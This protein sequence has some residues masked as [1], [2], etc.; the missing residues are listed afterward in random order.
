MIPL[1]S[2]TMKLNATSEMIP[3]H[4]AGVRRTSIRSRRPSSAPATTLLRH[5]LRARGCAR[6]PAMPASACSPTPARRANTRACWRSAPGTRRAAKAQ[7]DGLP[8]SGVGARHQPGERADGR[9]AGGRD[10]VRREGNVDLAD[11]E[12]RCVAHRDK[13]AAVMITYPST[14]RRVRD[15][16][17][18]SCARSST[19]TAAA[20]TSTAPT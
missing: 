7:R 16:A 1:G 9:H 20:S 19:P 11:L 14:L 17:S 4:L 2:C 8:D 6:R 10:E 3:D 15:A 13:L 18:R 5:Q 12:A